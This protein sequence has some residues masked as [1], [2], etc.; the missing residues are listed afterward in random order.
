R[1]RGRPP[2]VG[3]KVREN[4]G[5]LT[6]ESH[7]RGRPFDPG[8]DPAEGDRLPRFTSRW[9]DGRGTGEGTDVQPVGRFAIAAVGRLADLEQIGLV[10]GSNEGE[11]SILPAEG[12]VVAPGDFVPLAIPQD[13]HR[14]EERPPGAE[15][16]D[17]DRE[18][19]TLF[20]V[21]GVVV[22][23]LK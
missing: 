5:P 1:R 22:D 17:F 12:E 6:R 14:I 19:L 15:P 10:F 16:F 9:I 3:W 21:D 4:L 8:S 13:E 18:S 7:L 11:G 20:D 2:L 23:I